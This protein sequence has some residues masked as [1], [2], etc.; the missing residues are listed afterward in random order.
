MN[1]K[2]IVVVVVAAILAL[3]A[4]AAVGRNLLSQTESPVTRTDLIR[5]KDPVAKISIAYPA[6][7]RRLAD[8]PQDPELVLLAAV[9]DATSLLMRVSASGLEVPVT[10]EALPVVRGYTD[11]LLSADDRAKQLTEPAAVVV[12]GLPGWRYRYTY[13]SGD[14]GGA[15]D[16]YFLFK[17]R[18]LVQL[19]FQAIPAQRLPAVASQFDAIAD[20]FRG[21]DA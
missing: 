15:H 3:L 8:R 1:R 17:D 14:S 16:H 10:R 6:T 13:G 21:R 12:G 20:S 5:F 2:L 9:G 11:S 18:K 4:G 19:V 7:W